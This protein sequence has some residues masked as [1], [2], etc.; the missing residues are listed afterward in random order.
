MARYLLELALVEYSMLKYSP[1]N[2]AASAIYLAAKIFKVKNFWND[3]VA[4]AV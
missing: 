1:A 4:D 3:I 2:V